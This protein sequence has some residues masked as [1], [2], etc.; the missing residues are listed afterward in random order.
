MI[1]PAD[2]VHHSPA[3][4]FKTLQVFLIYL[5]KLLKFQHHTLLC[6]K[7]STLLVSALKVQFAV[8]R[9]FFLLKAAFTLGVL[10][11]W[12]SCYPHT[13]NIPH[14]QSIVIC[15]EGGFLEIPITQFFFS[16]SFQF[17]NTFLASSTRPSVYCTLRFT[18]HILKFPISSLCLGEIPFVIMVC[19]NI[20]L[21]FLCR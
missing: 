9:V 2:P 15:I 1:G 17:C 8:K 21:I 13:S 11:H 12:I 7:C 6:S 14:S 19:C 5:L 20:A 3:P 18:C 10:H 4:H 16:H